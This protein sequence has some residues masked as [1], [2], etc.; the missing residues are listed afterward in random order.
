M[1]QQKQQQLQEVFYNK[2]PNLKELVSETSLLTNSD[3]DYLTPYIAPNQ[4]RHL[5]LNI[6]HD[7]HPT[8]QIFTID[9]IVSNKSFANLPNI[10]AV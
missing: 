3:N 2:H 6:I 1:V 4:L 5:R 7:E 9:T 8:P 10:Y